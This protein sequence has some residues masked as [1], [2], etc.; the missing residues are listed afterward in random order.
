M[1]I[2]DGAS[3]HNEFFFNGNITLNEDSSTK[4]GGLTQHDHTKVIA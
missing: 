3:C 2:Q 4:F 1:K